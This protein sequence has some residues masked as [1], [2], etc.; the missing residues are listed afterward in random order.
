MLR[1]Q[2][3]PAMS[4]DERTR[5]VL[6]AGMGAA[7]NLQHYAVHVD[8]IIGV[9]PNPAMH[10]WARRAAA[11]AGAAAKLRLVTGAAEALP[12][13]TSSVDAVI[14]THVRNDLAFSGRAWVHYRGLRQLRA[15]NRAASSTAPAPGADARRFTIQTSFQRRCCAQCGTSSSLWQRPEGC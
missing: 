10:P 9:D 2:A 8:R 15:G 5:L 7:P 1:R 14:M 4:L 11:A 3:C 6:V 13:E 12:L